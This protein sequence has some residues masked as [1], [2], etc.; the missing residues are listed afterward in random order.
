M[1][2]PPLT[3]IS[4]I[5]HE[6]DLVAVL[7]KDSSALCVH[8]DE[9]GR[10]L[11]SLRAE[12]LP[13]ESYRGFV[14]GAGGEKREVRFDVVR[15]ETP[16]FCSGLYLATQPS[17]S[18]VNDL[19]AYMGA[20]S[21]Q[22]CVHPSYVETVLKELGAKPAGEGKYSGT[23]KDEEGQLVEIVFE[24]LLRL[25]P[26]LCGSGDDDDR[27]APAPGDGGSPLP[28]GGAPGFA[29]APGTGGLPPSGSG[30]T[31]GFSTGTGGAATGTGGVSSGTGGTSTG[32]DGGSTKPKKKVDVG[33]GAP[34]VNK[35]VY[36]VYKNAD[37]T[38]RVAAGSGQCTQTPQCSASPPTI[39]NY[40]KDTWPDHIRCAKGFGFCVETRHVPAKTESFQTAGCP[41]PASS[42]YTYRS[43]GCQVFD[44]TNTPAPGDG[45]VPATDLALIEDTYRLYRNAHCVTVEK[46]KATPCTAS[47]NKSKGQYVREVYQ[48]RMACQ[49]GNG[50]CVETQLPIGRREYFDLMSTA[51]ECSTNLR[52]EP[53]E[54]DACLP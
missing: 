28:T 49:K 24:L 17:P 32:T 14:T 45:G 2:E 31:G 9:V 38:N 3:P 10:A 5:D 47:T 11:G 40:T 13:D 48:A 52:T 4:N 25:A 46:P 42:S 12:Q 39:C 22:L 41:P 37:C 35:G 18:P 29:G 50:Y 16:W 6:N 33:P 53:I 43:L 15:T 20:N 27:G 8:P 26:V 23:V 7:A 51:G 1:A 44:N 30:G 21:T 34:V 36:A 54:L 19:V